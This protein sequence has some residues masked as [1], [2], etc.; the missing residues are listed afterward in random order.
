MA[1]SGEMEEQFMREALREVR[2]RH[3]RWRLFYIY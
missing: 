3:H 1:M 2:V